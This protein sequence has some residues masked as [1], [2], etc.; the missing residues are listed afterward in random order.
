[1]R[2]FFATHPTQQLFRKVANIRQYVE[3]VVNQ[4]IETNLAAE[5][6]GMKDP[7]AR[8]TPQLHRALVGLAQRNQQHE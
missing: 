5:Y 8:A 1:M 2:E 6:C 7:G 4:C 3:K